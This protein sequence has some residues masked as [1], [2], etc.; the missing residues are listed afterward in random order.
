MDLILISYSETAAGL[1]LAANK[2]KIPIKIQTATFFYAHDSLE[3]LYCSKRTIWSSIFII[4]SETQKTH[5]YNDLLKIVIHLNEV[6]FTCN[7]LKYMY[8][9]D[10]Y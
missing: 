6:H 8:I 1:L 4:D 5:N 3:D 10:S 2:Y 7:D 9:Y